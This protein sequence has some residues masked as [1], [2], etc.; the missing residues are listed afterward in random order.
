M[1]HPSVTIK[2]LL[3]QQEDRYSKYGPSAIKIYSSLSKLMNHNTDKSLNKM[4]KELGNDS[5]R[6]RYQT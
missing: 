2:T 6:G 5:E 3:S 1:Q 4:F